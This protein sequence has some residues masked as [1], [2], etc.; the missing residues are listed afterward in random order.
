MLNKLVLCLVILLTNNLFASN[1]LKEKTEGKF[2]DQKDNSK[3][4]YNF[5]SEPHLEGAE[6]RSE[7]VY[8]CPDNRKDQCPD[9]KLAAKEEIYYRDGKAYMMNLNNYQIN[10]S[11]S[12]VVSGSKIKFS[13]IN[14]GEKK[15]SDETLSDPVLFSEE[16]IPYMQKNWETLEKGDSMFFRFPVIFRLETVGFKIFKD[17]EEKIDGKD[18]FVVEMKPSSIIIQAIVKPIYFYFDK[19]EKKIL[20]VDGRTT[21]KEKVDGTYKDL[22]AVLIL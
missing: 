14:K 2:V 15:E 20:K 3:V 7:R 22:D 6:V 9:G 1:P 8:L 13:Y 21:P 11:G 10:T 5:K 17:R 18:T 12:A 16:L 19:T 4:L